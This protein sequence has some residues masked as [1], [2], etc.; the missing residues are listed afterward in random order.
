MLLEK[1]GAGCVGP[2]CCPG[3]AVEPGR[4]TDSPGNCVREGVT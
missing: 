1:G 4:L 3:E 2:V